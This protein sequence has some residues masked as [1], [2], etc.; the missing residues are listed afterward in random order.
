[1]G[2]SKLG[3]GRKAAVQELRKEVPELR[4]DL[5]ALGEVAEELRESLNEQVPALQAAASQTPCSWTHCSTPTFPA[6][7]RY[8]SGARSRS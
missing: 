4:K 8:S 1:M 7:R 2:Y 3:N 6:T 5:E